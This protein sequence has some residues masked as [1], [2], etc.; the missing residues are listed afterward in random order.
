[1]LV[2]LAFG[3]VLTLATA[4]GVAVSWWALQAALLRLQAWTAR[5]SHGSRLI[6]VLVL[7]LIWTLC[8][9]AAAVSLWAVA[10]H[11]LAVFADAEEA[12]YF[13]LVSFTTLG[14]GDILLPEKWRLLGGIA[15]VNGLLLFG[16]LV[17]VLVETLRSIRLSQQGR[18]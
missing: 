3:S 15:A 6:A 9:I 7:A 17:A 18:K 11:G 14:F 8:M 5:S 16:L 13:A 2:Q 10:F 12:V 4:L 1:M